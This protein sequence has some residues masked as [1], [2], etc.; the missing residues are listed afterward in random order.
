MATYAGPNTNTATFSDTNG[1][2]MGHEF[3]VDTSGLYLAGVRCLRNTTTQATPTAGAVWSISGTT[4][5]TG[6]LVSGS[7]FTWTGVGTSTGVLTWTY[8]TALGPLVAN[9]RYRV[10]VSFPGS[11]SATL[12]GNNLY[13]T[14]GPGSAGETFGPL[15]FPNAANATQNAQGCYNVGS[16]LTFPNTTNTNRANFSVGVV[17]TDVAPPGT[18]KG[19]FFPFFGA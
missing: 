3:Y 18:A 1:R 16:T 10:G 9:Q 17:I 11:A 12:H 4:T 5:I 13:W 2:T 15:I 7:Q 14:T 6:T 8:A 19:G